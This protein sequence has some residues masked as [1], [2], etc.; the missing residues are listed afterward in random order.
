MLTEAVKLK[1]IKHQPE[2]AYLF[3]QYGPNLPLGA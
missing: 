1:G 3:L 2:Q